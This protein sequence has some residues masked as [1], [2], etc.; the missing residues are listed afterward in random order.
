MVELEVG[1]DDPGDFFGAYAMIPKIPSQTAG[2]EAEPVPCHLRFFGAYTSIY[3]DALVSVLDKQ[4]VQT[5]GDA[6]S[7]VRRLLQFPLHLGHGAKN[8]P[9]IELDYSVA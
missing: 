8:T 5:H 1:E 4:T 9:S 3:Q 7:A 6:V 2:A